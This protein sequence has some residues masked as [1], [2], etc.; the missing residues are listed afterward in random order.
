MNNTRKPVFSLS[1][2]GTLLLAAAGVFS[3]SNSV[4][5]ANDQT[6][7]QASAGDLVTLS[8]FNFS[9][10]SIPLK[11]APAQ[12]QAQLLLSD[13]PE[14]T[15][16]NGVLLREAVEPGTVRLYIYQ[17]ISGST[18]KVITS[19]IRNL[20]SSPMKVSFSKCARVKPSA[21]YNR[22]A[23]DALDIFLSGSMT[24]N[25][26]TVPPNGK[27]VIDSGL[28]KF[29]ATNDQLTHGIYE[30]DVDQ[31]AVVTVFAR[32]TWQ[33]SVSV[34]DNLPILP[35]NENGAGR[36]RFPVSNFT[37]ESAAVD[38]TS[39]PFQFIV[40]DGQTD[41]WV[42]GNDTL[43]GISGVENVGNYGTFYRFRIKYT[44]S[45]GRGLALVVT[46]PT[47]GNDMCRYLATAMGV[48][49]P[50][51]LVPAQTVRIPNGDE[52]L[53]VNPDVVVI[54]KLPPLTAGR[55]GTVD[56]LYSP[57]GAA[58]LPTPLVFVPYKQ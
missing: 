51:G 9:V 27:A 7:S 29:S 11:I 55:T 23:Q 46:N 42:A 13:N 34:V 26:F 54:Q 25:G 8:D 53:N 20:S 39:G 35:R 24:C 17:V 2:I 57:P 16:T 41:H 58:C 18:P 32:D 6:L 44:T 1:S 21:A 40:A 45:D 33:N 37:V 31:P 52:M 14:Y 19:V 4:S 3:A 48:S 50:D 15:S 47:G 28:E 56:L 5:A 36:G 38:S 12:G 43:A 49:S 30:F 10:P 22:V